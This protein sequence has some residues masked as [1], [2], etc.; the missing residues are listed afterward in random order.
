MAIKFKARVLLELGAELISSD[1]V[2]I[3]ELIKNGLDARSPVVDVN[4]SLAMQPSSFRR[5]ESKWS[6]PDQKWDRAEFLRDV[7]NELEPT[8]TP[9][10]KESFIADMGDPKDCPSAI[11]AL[12]RAV[13]DWNSIIISD[14]GHGMDSHALENTYLT[15]GTPGRL[16]EKQ[17]ILANGDPD[18][19]VPLGEKGI[20]RLA[21]MRLGHHVTVM[22]GT[23]SDK[24]WNIL[25]LDWRPVFEQ[26]DLDADAL[27][28]KPTSGTSKSA[29]E[30][31]TDIVIR[32]LQADWLPEK[33]SSLWNTD[34][35]KLSNPFAK[36]FNPD[37]LEINYQGRPSVPEHPFDLE[38]L[39]KADAYC[40]IDFTSRAEMTGEP[41]LT[42]SVEYR[43]FSAASTALYEGAHLNSLVSGPPRRT[44][45]KAASDKLP[46]TD[47]VIAALPT[48][49]DFSAEFYWFN[50]GRISR[51]TPQIWQD[52]GAF[53][54][55]W[56]G[57]LLVY[58]DGYR[59]YPYGSSSDDWLDLDRKA[60]A[61]SAF[62]LNR[63]QIVG[64]LSV[65]SL[66]N[67]KLKDQTNREGFRDCPEKEALRRLLRQAIIGDCR[68]LLEKVDKEMK[69]LQPQDVDS[70]DKTIDKSKSNAT[71]SLLAIQRRVPSER[72]A[73]EDILAQLTDVEDA[74]KR[75]K[76]ALAEKGDQ[77]QQYMHLA[78][79]GLTVEFIAHELARSTEAALEVLRSS[80]NK[81]SEAQ[82]KSL[83]AQLNTINKRVRVID[84]LSIPG[85]QTKSLQDL[86]EIADLVGEVYEA[87]ATRHGISIEIFAT[88][89]PKKIRIERGQVIQ[90]MDNLMSNSMYWL[91]HRTDRKL[92]PAVKIRVDHDRS[93]I[94][95]EDSGP[96]IPASIGCR[97][98]DAFF[99]TK[100]A[101]AGRGL[102]LAI[103]THLA[104][105]NDASISLTAPV[106]GVHHGFRINFK[107]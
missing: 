64:H 13:F 14:T 67:P 59:V 63:A 71:K 31:G 40:K 74:W 38:L 70:L 58:R 48:L 41:K 61:S 90:I 72:A 87:K 23:L 39:E 43:R 33:L 15:I 66:H 10:T 95:V 56:S 98:F 94:E 18:A 24:A 3:Y 81:L 50:R 21:A 55:A 17:A 80:N 99:T 49:G 27:D 9:E 8:T 54:G 51:E 57:G 37:F 104:E 100:P 82:L 62:K 11:E 91:A 1:S 42:V 5:I 53:I 93:T 46:G 85:R 45:R 4:I 102:G 89:K 78:G 86:Q 7:E 65:S 34:L 84:E 28:F 88:G 6:E 105:S 47:E 60:L 35:A 76:I 30:Q 20:G 103:A 22:T 101:G 68:S 75:A 92:P 44:G 69:G 16:H 79:V 52:I 96:G 12:Q 29:D 2:A 26:S 106:D 36:K 32:D 77:I 83:R 107:G 73:I 25:E 97:I 19:V